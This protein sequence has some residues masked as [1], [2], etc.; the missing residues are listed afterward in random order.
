[1]LFLRGHLSSKVDMIFVQ[2]SKKGTFCFGVSN[3]LKLTLLIGCQNQ[4]KLCVFDYF[5]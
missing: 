5:E 4:Q 3:M 2:K 1:M